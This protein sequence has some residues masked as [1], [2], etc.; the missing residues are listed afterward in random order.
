MLDLTLHVQLTS[1]LGRVGDGDLDEDHVVGVGEV[2][3][4]AH[5]AQLVAVVSPLPPVRFLC[6][7]PDGAA[8]GVADEQL[9]GGIESDVGDTQLE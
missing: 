7:E 6:N 3:V 2:V 4:A 5:L 8:G 9:R 1:E